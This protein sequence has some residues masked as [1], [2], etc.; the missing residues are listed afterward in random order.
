MAKLFSLAAVLC[1]C[2]MT[3][4]LATADTI[5]LILD[6]EL[7]LDAAAFDLENGDPV[8]LRFQFDSALQD[9]MTSLETIE[10]QI[11][12]QDFLLPADQSLV[13][14]FLAVSQGGFSIQN[15]FNSF[16]GNLNGIDLN[17]QIFTAVHLVASFSTDVIDADTDPF[18]GDLEFSDIDS[19][20]S[21]VFQLTPGDLGDPNE[22]ILF[23][24]NFTNLTVTS[25]PEPNAA[26]LVLLGFVSASVTRHRRQ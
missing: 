22:G 12:G 4:A 15:S 25:I 2:L 9:G 16:S 1:L 18:P 8:Q 26:V 7:E 11:N 14:S 24:V 13:N 19:S 3:T 20:T 10:F 5:Q 17:L 6:G 23:T 21:G